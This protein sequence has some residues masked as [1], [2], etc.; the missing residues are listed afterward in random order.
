[1]GTFYNLIASIKSI[2]SHDDSPFWNAVKKSEVGVDVPKLR[3]KLHDELDSSSDA[4]STVSLDDIQEDTGR[5][6]SENQIPTKG[7]EAFP[8]PYANRADNRRLP[9]IETGSAPTLSMLAGGIV[10][11]VGAFLGYRCLRRF[12]K[13]QP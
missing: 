6:Q 7:G 13:R 11:A 5:I 9:E 3:Q 12:R 1:M 4:F 10:L 8:D 2:N